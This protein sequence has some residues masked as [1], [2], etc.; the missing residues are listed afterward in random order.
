MDM[1]TGDANALSCEN[2]GGT[3]YKDAVGG[4][5]KR[6]QKRMLKQQLP[7]C[8]AS[9]VSATSALSPVDS[10]KGPAE[11][12]TSASADDASSLAW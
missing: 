7:A 8:G 4:P 5:S 11:V 10:T 12:D 2:G 1:A 6:K 3:S 9:D